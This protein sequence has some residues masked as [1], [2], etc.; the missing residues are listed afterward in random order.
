VAEQSYSSHGSWEAERQREEAAEEETPFKGTPQQPTSS[1]R[2]HLTQ[3][4]NLP[5]LHPI[6]NPSVDESID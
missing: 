2:P 3:F 1:S 5:T 4:Y 6:M